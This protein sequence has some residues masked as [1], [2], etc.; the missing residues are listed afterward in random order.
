M[1]SLAFL[2]T[3]ATLD[4]LLEALQRLPKM[5]RSLWR[6]S[7]GNIGRDDSNEHNVI[8]VSKE[9]QVRNLYHRS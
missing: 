8:M 4:M 6:D 2:K 1:T 7:G 5:L 3:V 9:R